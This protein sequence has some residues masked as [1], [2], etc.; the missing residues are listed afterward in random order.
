MSEIKAGDLV[1]VVRPTTCCNWSGNVG[2]IFRVADV[3][4]DYSECGCRYYGKELAALDPGDGTWCDV[5][6]LIKIDPPPVAEDVPAVEE[7]T[8]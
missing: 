8:A 4:L 3:S 1:M 5:S 2:E 7:L 6:Q